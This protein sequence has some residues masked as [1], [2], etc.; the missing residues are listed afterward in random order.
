METL[1]TACSEWSD[2]QT[3]MGTLVRRNG[4]MARMRIQIAGEVGGVEEGN[5]NGK[6]E[7]IKVVITTSKDGT[8]TTLLSAEPNTNP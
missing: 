5:G 4:L 8:T 7:G 3:L 1:S 6:I 2:S